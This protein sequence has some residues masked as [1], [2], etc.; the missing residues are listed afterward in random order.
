MSE[1]GLWGGRFAGGLDPAFAS[2]NQSLG[3]DQRLWREDVEGSRAW[4][5]ALGRAGVLEAADVQ[6]LDAALAELASELE[7]DP[8]PLGSSDAEDIHSFVEAALTEKVGNLARRLHTGREDCVPLCTK[9]GK[10]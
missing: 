2:F 1:K 5:A 4:A 7:E 10:E 8:S 6:R 3:F 9:E